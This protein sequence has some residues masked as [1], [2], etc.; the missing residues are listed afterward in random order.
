[1]EK[2]LQKTVQTIEV[3]GLTKEEVNQRVLEGKINRVEDSRSRSYSDIIKDHVFTYFNFV[4]LVLF[5]LIVI[6]GEYK[7]GLF[8]LT[9]IL[10]SFI[11]I[12]QD[13]KA[14]KIIDRLT[15]LV[16]SEIETL[17]DEQ[18][19]KVK[20]IDLVQD[21]LIKLGIGMQVPADSYVVEGY[22]E[23]NESIL[24]G[25][26]TNIVKN[27]GDELLAGTI[28]TSGEATA[29]II[30]VGKENYSETILKDAKKY[31][32]A[33]SMIREDTT[34][35][36][37]LISIAIVPLGISLYIVQNRFVGLLWQESIVKT[38]SALVGM[39]PEGLVVLTSVALT[40]SVIR[41]TRRDVLVQDIY[42]IE[43]LARVDVVCV[44]KTGTLTEGKMKV[45]EVIPLEDASYDQ[46]NTIMGSYMRIFQEGN[47]TNEALRAYFPINDKYQEVEVLPF[48]SDRKYSSIHFEGEGTFLLG[49]YEFIA[50]NKNEELEEKMKPYIEN[51]NRI[52]VLGHTLEEAS[53]QMTLKDVELLGFIVLEDIIREEAKNIIQYLKA[54]DVTVKVISGD[55]PR[56]VSSIAKQVG[57]DKAE[58]YVD[59]SSLH[60]NDLSVTVENGTVFGRVLPE[61]KKEMVLAL[62]RQGHTVAMVGDGVNDAPAL[63]LADVGI[64][65]ASGS[66]AAKNSANII[67]LTND[68]GKFPSI[69]NEGRRVINNISRAASMYLVK[70]VFSILLTLYSIFM[71]E[72]YVF[73]PIHLTIL[74]TFAV[75]IPTL[76]LQ[77]EPSFER[78]KGRF[79]YN[80]L[81][82]AIPSAVT[83]FLCAIL[84]DIL[85]AP[86]HLTSE[87]NH[88]LMLILTSYAYLYTLYKVYYPMN[89]HRLMIILS[90]AIFFILSIFLLNDLLEIDFHWMDLLILVPGVIIVP[91]LIALI[92]RIYDWFFRQYRKIR[93]KVVQ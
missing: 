18:W 61:Q 7:N 85:T 37:K 84:C 57:I 83:V 65:M 36:L 53:N 22:L 1:M 24:T 15:L 19:V 10:N 14:K 64:A 63:K 33:K 40:V 73:L 86:L 39:I 41:L 82:N 23:V 92:S 34:R 56:T 11:G 3:R 76:L 8:I 79:Y 5:I 58:R 13:L 6:T 42:S 4:N 28:I 72:S 77:M 29:K 93:H 87:R 44:D 71:V 59:L 26:S 51:G 17:R 88:A 32:T 78:I 31:N 12:I 67:L 50:L 90:M 55:N 9:I 47:D 43:S 70:T 45:K 20:T 49:A 91:L 35:L 25:E 38:V 69:I 54:Q 27:K 89:K 60:L 62:Q 80:A 66:S 2:T 21:D 68:F 52:L 75:G 30:R 46:I 16:M 48:S 74:S 81:R